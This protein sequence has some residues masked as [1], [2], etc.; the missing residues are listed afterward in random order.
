M[1]A[2]SSLQGSHYVFISQSYNICCLRLAVSGGNMTSSCCSHILAGLEHK[3]PCQLPLCYQVCALS[4]QLLWQ[5]GIQDRFEA[6]APVTDAQLAALSPDALHRQQQAAAVAA[7][8]VA[9]R[10]V[11]FTLPVPPDRGHRRAAVHRIM[12]PHLPPAP[13]P[14]V[15]RQAS[16][17][18][19]WSA[20]RMLLECVPNAPTFPWQS[21]IDQLNVLTLL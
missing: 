14:E 21:C 15:K 8:A 3:L 1:K 6:W 17:V 12:H 18:T 5:A 9:I 2:D 10:P 7:Q 19:A 11:H 4:A 13:K 20:V 16:K